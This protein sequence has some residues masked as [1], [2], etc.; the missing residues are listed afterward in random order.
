MNKIRVVTM[1]IV[2][3]MLLAMPGLAAG[4]TAT[5]DGSD[6]VV[7]WRV[8]RGHC[9]L[10]VSEDGWPICVRQVDGGKGSARIRVDD[11]TGSYNVRLKAPEGNY[12]CQVMGSVSSRNP[13]PDKSQNKASQALSSSGKSRDDLAGQVLELVNEERAA[14]GLAPMRMSGE[15]ERA[16]RVRAEEIARSFGHTRPDGTSW[17]TVSASAYGENIARG[18]KTAEKV[19]A[20]WMTSESH[21]GNILRESY[22]SIG[23]CAYS[24]NGVMYWVQLFGK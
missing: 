9:E 4:V 13:A 17:S 23:I 5:M 22:R 12:T 15:L 10:T 20:A 18:Q 2:M 1:M 11:F 21:R 19:I 16:A 6:I 8:G 14:R 3:S 7:T 24:V